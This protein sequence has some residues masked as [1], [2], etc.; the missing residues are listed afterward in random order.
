M[1]KPPKNILWGK[2][3]IADLSSLCPTKESKI[4]RLTSEMHTL[5]FR[6]G[7]AIT[8][9]LPINKKGFYLEYKTIIIDAINKNFPRDELDEFKRRY[10][11]L[12]DYF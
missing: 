5:I 2:Q 9:K 3:T 10:N 12:M 7:Q 11:L 1:N 6:L 4:E 8:Y